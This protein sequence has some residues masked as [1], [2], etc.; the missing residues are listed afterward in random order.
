MALH[1]MNSVTIGVPNVDDTRAFYRDFNLTE[2]G[3]G[4]FATADGGDQLKIVHAPRRQLI[5]MSVGADDQ[6]DID[7]VAS[8]LAAIGATASKGETNDFDCDII[9]QNG[10]FTAYPQGV[11]T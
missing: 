2:T 7:R 1:R 4:V 8:Q 6:D 3:P 9:Y 5:E 10:V 11:Q